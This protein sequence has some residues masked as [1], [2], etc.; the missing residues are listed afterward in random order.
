MTT[1]CAIS[2]LWIAIINQHMLR[3]YSLCTL[4]KDQI[5]TTGEGICETLAVS[6][7]ALIVICI[8]FID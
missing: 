4:Q 2:F 5:E 7:E 6:S 3:L 8:V 1:L